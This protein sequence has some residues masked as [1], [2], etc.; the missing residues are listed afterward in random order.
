[1]RI[2]LDICRVLKKILIALCVFL[3][4]VVPLI[5]MY[6]THDDPSPLE[7]FFHAVLYVLPLLP[8]LLMLLL[9]VIAAEQWLQTKIWD[10]SRTKLK[11]RLWILAIC[12]I[13]LLAVVLAMVIMGR[14][15]NHSLLM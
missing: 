10:L 14:E 15:I 5:T 4:I 1:M 2:C 7:T 6:T 3:L 8:C 11:R 13:I 9:P 12:E